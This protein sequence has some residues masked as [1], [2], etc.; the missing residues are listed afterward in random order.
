MRARGEGMSEDKRA[1]T[2]AT[3]GA[4][5]V[6]GASSGRGR[7]PAGA[8]L[9]AVALRLGLLAATSGSPFAESLALDSHLYSAMADAILAGDSPSATAFFVDPLYAYFLAAVYLVTGHSLL[10]VRLLQIVMGGISCLLAAWLGR[11]LGGDRRVGI[12]AGVGTAA[13]PL[14]IY[15]D[16]QVL[17]TSLEIF[18]CLAG[19]SLFVRA[20]ARGDRGKYLLAGGVLGCG[21]LT[22]GALL[23]WPPALAAW[24]VLAAPR[25]ERRRA[26]GHGAT[27]LLGAVL[28]ILPVTVRNALVS[29]QFV[30]TTYNAGMNLW[31]GNNP[32]ADGGY[33]RPSFVRGDPLFEEADSRV[34]AER[35]SGRALGPAEISAFWF[36]ET[37]RFVVENPGAALRLLGRKALLFW[38]HHEVDDNISFYF[39]REF[40]GYLSLPFPGFRL[41]GPLGLAGLLWSLAAWRRWGPV[42]IPAAAVMAGT[43]AFHVIDRYR[44]PAV[45]FLVILGASLACSAW[46]AAISRRFGRAAIAAALVAG[47]A[48]LVNVPSFY[49][50]AETYSRP[51]YVLCKYYFEH[52]ADQPAIAACERS[53]AIDAG[54]PP[55][56]QVLAKALLRSGRAEDSL[57][58]FRA[59]LELDPSYPEA[60][61]GEGIALLRLGRLAEAE[62]AFRRVL[63]LAPD[64]PAS[65]WLG[66]TALAAGEGAAAAGW[67]RAALQRGRPPQAIVG[68][69][70]ALLLQGDLA[71]AREVY[72]EAPAEVRDPELDRQL[73]AAA[74]R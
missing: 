56:H 17:K 70:R 52:D 39:T 55:P 46:D 7:V 8:F 5:Q 51:Y 58:H 71:A 43:I 72:A 16:L 18:L 69:A 30:P 6:R 65:F 26:A 54:Y 19:V 36:G 20:R 28:C 50:P 60:Y 63:A 49:A 24:L 11:E 41:W 67:F 1:G 2:A 37:R 21:A 66:Q 53:L 4:G 45:P 47:T 48:L 25:Q 9:L 64:G 57:P 10:W 62:A 38:N 73:G 27:F 13:Y 33:R 14:L 61:Y 35:R 44:L 74:P 3:G 59:S 34:E 22:H 15:Y 32:E 29:G 31:E 23:L 42:L 40:V 12:L 68:L